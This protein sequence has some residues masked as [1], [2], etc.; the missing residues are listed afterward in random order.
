M[1]IRQEMPE[2]LRQVVCTRGQVQLKLELVIRFDYGSVVPWVRR[3]ESGIS[4]I[5][6]PD[7]IRLR[8]GAPLHG[9]NMKTES[10]FTLSEGQKVSFDLTWYPSHAPEPPE[11]NIDT[12]IQRTEQWWREWSGR[13]SYQGKWR[14]A[15]LRSLITLKGLT[16]LPTG[17][18]VAAPT[19][20][21]PELIGGVRN[22]DYRFC[23][24]RD[25]TLTL[26]SLLNAGYLD[27]ARDWRE[28]LLRAV[29]GSPS[30]L[31]IL[32]GIRG[33]RRLTELEL[34]WLQGYERSTPVRTGNAA[35]TQYQLDI[36]GEVVNTLFQAREA[37]LEPAKYSR[38]EVALAMLEFLETGWKRPDE[39]IWEVRGPRRHFV[40]SK[41]MAWVAVDRL[42]R[43]AERWRF[44]VEVGRWKKLREDIHEEVCRQGFDPDM[45]SFVQYYGGKFLDASILMMPLVGFLPADDPRVKGTVEAIEK[46]LMRNGFVGR[47][48]QDP[49]VDGLP[50]GEGTF[51]ACSFWLADN[52]EL[53]GRH[54]D[55]VRMFERLLEI[56][57]DVGLLAEEYDPVAKRQLGNFP[58]AFSHVGLVNTAFNLTKR[59]GEPV[60][61]VSS[62]KAVEQ[63]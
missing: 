30:E 27:E 46:H 41:M 42:V 35:Y 4:A 15:V 24:V 32:Y 2:L 31:N 40:H 48:T 51:L 6:G 52:Y 56:R 43:S 54:Q 39:G 44:K 59:S 53:Q 63:V 45:N 5:A 29:A 22:W 1:I 34:P 9:E 7:M 49:A 50:H 28:W 58:Q 23:W 8:S 55:A 18:I 11:V 33:E 62:S 13:C 38:Y 21:L 3:T 10:E 17:G 57:N 25:A 60:G 47:Y 61:A 14:E 19:T 20:S 26:Q 16:F 36:F 12:A 37:G